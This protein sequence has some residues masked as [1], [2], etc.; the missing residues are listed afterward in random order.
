MGARVTS[1]KDKTPV[2][3]T[4]KQPS[5]AADVERFLAEIAARPRPVGTGMGRLIFAMDAT[6]SRQ[7]TWDL[8]AQLQGE[9]FAAAAALGG[10]ST[11]VC[12]YRGFGEFRVSP[13]LNQPGA[14]H[15]LMSSV[16]CRA[17]RTQI[18]KVLQHAINET[19]RQKVSALV[20]VGDCCEEELDPLAGLAGDLGVFGVPAFMFQEGNDV[21]ARVAFQE[22][23]RLT[24]GAWCPFDQASADMLRQLLRA[25]AV[26]VAGGRAALEDLAKRE[27]DAA[28]L[29]TRQLDGR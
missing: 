26:F 19:R 24:R 8:A 9:M 15:R 28:R 23:A 5:S 22:I 1:D 3:Q 13:W 6:A 29:L 4:F 21:A 17:G 14:V 27:H 25:V 2:K 12:F 11:Q 20:F 7:P 10:F 18:A 16:V